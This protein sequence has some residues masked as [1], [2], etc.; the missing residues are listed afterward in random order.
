[1]IHFVHRNR[2]ST[3]NNEESASETGARRDVG[4]ND[5]FSPEA[6]ATAGAYYAS[7]TQPK[8]RSAAAGH[9]S[10]ALVNVNAAAAPAAG[11]TA[12]A[13]NMNYYKANNA[14]G[15][16]ATTA[17]HVSVRQRGA[18]ASAVSPTNKRFNTQPAAAPGAGRT[19]IIDDE[20]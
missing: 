6:Q 3:L 12:P 2:R 18:A 13:Q 14:Q 11:A 5:D 7:P 10:P 1:M 9:A 19:L 8:G 16:S 15:A 20:D 17:T 4:S